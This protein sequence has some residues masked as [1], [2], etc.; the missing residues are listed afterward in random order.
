[1]KS[2]GV[3]KFPTP[4]IRLHIAQGQDIWADFYG[5]HEYDYAY[6]RRLSGGRY[7]NIY[8]LFIHNQ[9]FVFTNTIIQTRCF[10]KC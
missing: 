4:S 6:Y 5:D 7:V 8:K 2:W 1:M 9:Q 10:F 3:P